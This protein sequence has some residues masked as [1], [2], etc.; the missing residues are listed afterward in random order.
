[1]CRVGAGVGG[2]VTSGGG[3]ADR[4]TAD[5]QSSRNKTQVRMRYSHRLPVLIISHKVHSS[6][7]TLRSRWK[8]TLVGWW[9][10][11]AVVAP[12]S[13]SPPAPL[14]IT[15]TV[16]EVLVCMCPR[17]SIVVSCVCVCVSRLLCRRGLSR[18]LLCTASWGDEA[19]CGGLLRGGQLRKSEHVNEGGATRKEQEK[20][21]RTIQSSAYSFPPLFPSLV[22]LYV[23][24]RAARRR[25]ARSRAERSAQLSLT[26]FRR[27]T[28][29]RSSCVLC[30]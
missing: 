17:R 21:G 26:T 2:A 9:H 6:R 19:S 11:R 7:P 14:L 4:L 16:S 28:A 20:G 18:C 29:T 27:P 30:L 24:T 10:A 1:M 8:L 13:D 12:A 15:V 3:A 5:Q 25:P 22:I 23:H